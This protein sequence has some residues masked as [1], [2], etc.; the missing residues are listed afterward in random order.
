MKEMAQKAKGLT[1]NIKEEVFLPSLRK[2]VL[3]VKCAA[4]YK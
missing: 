3:E 4:M 1:E 2:S